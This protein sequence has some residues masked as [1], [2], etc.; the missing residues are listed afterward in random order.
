MTQF[1]CRVGLHR[2]LVCDREAFEAVLSSCPCRALLQ[3]PVEA[4]HDAS[5]LQ[6]R[7]AP[8]NM[9]FRTWVFVVFVVAG[10]RALAL[11]FKGS[12]LS[13]RLCS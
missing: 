11:V 7:G 3:P 12:G 4:L 6:A 8:A 5:K 10:M 1:V 9:D 2:T 13:I